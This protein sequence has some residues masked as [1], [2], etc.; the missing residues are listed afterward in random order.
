MGVRTIDSADSETKPTILMAIQ[1]EKDDQVRDGRQDDGRGAQ[2]GSPHEELARDDRVAQT[3][4]FAEGQGERDAVLCVAEAF[5]LDETRASHHE[6]E[7][8][9]E[10]DDDIV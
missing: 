7:G 8:K 5:D 3:R 10:I 9:C 1:D 4:N 6:D 2:G